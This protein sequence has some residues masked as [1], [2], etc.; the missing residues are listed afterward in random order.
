MHPSQ[1]INAE[2]LETCPVLAKR[3]GGPFLQSRDSGLAKAF[4]L[5]FFRYEIH[6]NP[7][8]SKCF[9]LQPFVTDKKD[10]RRSCSPNYSDLYKRFKGGLHHCVDNPLLSGWTKHT[11]NTF[12]SPRTQYSRSTTPPWSLSAVTRFLG[13]SQ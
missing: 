9:K 5:C 12:P 4:T 13:G 1:P 2:S 10:K 11:Q 3:S 7:R 6:C 8:L